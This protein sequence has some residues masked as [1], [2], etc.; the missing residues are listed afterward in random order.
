M[1]SKSKKLYYSI[2][3]VAEITGVAPHILRYWEQE[4]RCLKPKRDASKVRKYR[5]QDILLIQIVK[6][7]LQNHQFTISGAKKRLE[8]MGY[9][10]H[11]TKSKQTTQLQNITNT[12]INNVN[13]NKNVTELKEE[14]I[15]VDYRKLLQTIKFDLKQL[16]NLL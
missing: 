14:K 13:E 1:L 11:R 2:S 4:F 9:G 15:E 12:L 6:D 8:E 10:E 3:E 16:I 5:D 7:L